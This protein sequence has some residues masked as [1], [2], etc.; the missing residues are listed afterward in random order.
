M[1]TMAAFVEKKHPELYEHFPERYKNV[2][3]T[4]ALSLHF[5]DDLATSVLLTA[6]E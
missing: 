5:M 1:L 6:K 3:M 2:R 4:L